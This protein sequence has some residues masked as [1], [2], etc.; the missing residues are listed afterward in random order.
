MTFTKSE[1]DSLTK[2]AI[3]EWKCEE[4]RFG[5]GSGKEP[6][7]I[8]KTRKTIETVAPRFFKAMNS[9]NPPKDETE[10]VRMAMPLGA[11]LLAF[12]IKT[13]AEEV[14]RWLYRRTQN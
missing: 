14:I 2:A 5:Y 7:H 12:I 3:A 10:A 4:V 6:K 11:W 8:R 1:I 9:R 13:I